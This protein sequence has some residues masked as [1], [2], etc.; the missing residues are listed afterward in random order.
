MRYPQMRRDSVRRLT[1]LA[2]LSA[3][4]L[5]M[6]FTPLGYL[7]IGT[8]EITFI[9]VPVAIGAVFLGPGAGAIL[10]L[11]FGLTSFSQSF[12]SPLGMIFLEVSVVRSFI[13]CVVPRVLVGLLTGL[14]YRGVKRV[15]GSD[16]VTF[17]IAG[18]AAPLLNTALYMSLNF[19]LFQKEWLSVA[20]SM[21]GFTGATGGLALF[22]FLLASVTV[23]AVA[24]A[25][26]GLVVTSA[27][28]KALSRALEKQR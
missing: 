7:R 18:L 11:V 8:L 12:S 21:L 23:N 14:I 26:A 13:A 10:G 20:Q 25:L 16:L 27:L 22:G 1:E 19:L 24:E 9:T 5:L 6:A 15:L 4:I 2:L 28:C 3:I 17:V